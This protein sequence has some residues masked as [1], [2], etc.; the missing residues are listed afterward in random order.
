[1]PHILMS[2]A[3]TI[4]AASALEADATKV[5][6]TVQRLFA[7]HDDPAAAEAVWVFFRDKRIADPAA[8]LADL[9]WTYDPH[10]VQR[11]RLRRSSPG[12]FDERDLPVSAASID[13][14][15]STGASERVCSRWLNAVSVNATREQ[16]NEIAALDF[17]E[18]VQPVIRTP[19]E[20]GTTANLLASCS[21]EPIGP[22]GGI[23]Y[24]LSEPQL[25][26]I[27]VI[28][29]HDLGFTGEGVRIGVLDTGFRR[30]HDG[31]NHPNHPLDVVAEWDFVDDDPNT[32]PEGGDLPN[33]HEHGTYILGTLAAYAPGAYIGTAF[34]ASFIL[35]K[36]EDLA[37]EYA[38]EEDFFVAGLEFIEQNGGDVATS[39]VVIF[40]HYS[41]DEL[42]GMT[43]VMSIGLN[44]AAINGLHCF[45]GAGNEGHDS[46]PDTQRL[47]PP[48]D[49]FHVLTCGA[50]TS[51]GAISG[52]S[53]DGP[54]ADGRIK[55]EILA[56]GSSVPTVHAGNDSSYVNVSGTSLSTPLVAGAVACIAQR[57]PS[58]TVNQM[59]DALFHTTSEFLANGT[60]DATF[61]R[62]YGIVDALAASEHDASSF[63]TIT[64]VDVV[65]G[66]AFADARPA[67]LAESDDRRFG[68]LSGFGETLIE[69]HLLEA[70]ITVGTDAAAATSVDL[71]IEA[72]IDEP[73]GTA[74]LALR[75]WVS[76]AFEP[77][78]QFPLG[79]SDASA[80]FNGLSSENRISDAGEIQIQI[81][82]T[83]FV[84][85][86]AF[87]FDSFI[88]RIVVRV[89]E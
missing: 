55:P 5:H 52:F 40:N 9:E 2:I 10:A 11:R 60:Y 47:V 17:V 73:S 61:V 14:V 25:N 49:A 70:V 46:N 45:Q 30:T 62:G 36:V 78:G 22:E 13:A 86:L 72:A 20:R 74:R 53:S 43:S 64:H 76:G 82:H 50:V 19:V 33:Q 44:V 1:M 21:F 80:E 88:D 34:D 42:D 71:L 87:Q 65:T 6:P 15:L 57:R 38:G 32:A 85:F 83:V 37:D 81:K 7:D 54:S 31:F 23:D 24:G 28:A 29:L 3:L 39:S 48:A 16:V 66:S 56:R 41:Q 69:L 89:V 68:A 12:L 58:W 18:K 35:A 67:D 59:R 27:N 26:Q 4:G 51:T 84:P 79:M 8:A 75:N 77:I 63:A